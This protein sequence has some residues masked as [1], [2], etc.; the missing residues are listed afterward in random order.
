MKRVGWRWWVVMLLAVCV[1]R[2][3]APESGTEAELTAVP[4]EGVAAVAAECVGEQG[5]NDAYFQMHDQIFLQMGDWYYE[6][7][8]SGMFIQYA[9]S[10]GY[11]INT[12]I[13]DEAMIA[14]VDADY[15][16][17]RSYGVSGTPTFFINGKKLV[18]A[19][20]YEVFEQLIEAEL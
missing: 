6:E 14:E 3:S 13:T 10:L 8:P 11:D 5:G 7:D 19:Y 9:D 16:A 20:P 18:G 17:G 2:C 4:D 1:A 12:C 15:A